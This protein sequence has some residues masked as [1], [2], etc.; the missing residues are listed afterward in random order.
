MFC[1]II[2]ISA[3]SRHSSLQQDTSK[4]CSM[5]TLSE[6]GYIRLSFS[7][8]ETIRLMH[9]ISGLDE[10]APETVSSGA[11]ST[12]ITGY[13]EWISCTTP[14]IT[15]G[16][17]WLM[18]TF[19]A[20]LTLIR[21]GEP[22]SNIMLEDSGKLELGPIK[23]AALLEVFIDALDWQMEVLEHIDLRYAG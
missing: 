15:I 16:W 22:R 5:P 7:R 18:E 23:T 4:Q 9:L 14:I 6:D 8:L 20:P 17:D 2:A 10:D 1:H 21:I 13:T 11:M 12:T 19:G 3:M